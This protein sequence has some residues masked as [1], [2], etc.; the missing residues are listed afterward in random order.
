MVEAV[1]RRD[2]PAVDEDH[3]QDR[4]PAQAIQRRYVG[5]RPRLAAGRA[6]A[7]C[8]DDTLIDSRIPPWPCQ[9]SIF[10]TGPYRPAGVGST[11]ETAPYRAAGLRGPDTGLR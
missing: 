10:P 4:D 11:R 6:R 5:Q 2:H 9:P 7:P 1:D 8:A 3:E